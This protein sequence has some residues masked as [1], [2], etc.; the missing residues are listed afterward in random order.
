MG[1]GVPPPLE[2]DFDRQ[3]L[4]AGLV[5]DNPADHP[6]NALVMC[7]KDRIQFVGVVDSSLARYGHALCV[8]IPRTNGRQILWQHDWQKR[9][10]DPVDRKAGFASNFERSVLRGRRRSFPAR[11]E[12]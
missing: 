7:A 11:K 9:G 4:R 2:K 12:P 5:V 1:R 8:H 3:F 10:R 6:G